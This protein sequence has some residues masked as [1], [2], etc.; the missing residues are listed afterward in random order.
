MDRSGRRTMAASSAN[1]L[2]VPDRFEALRDSASTSLST[3]IVAV[4]SALATIDDYFHDMQAA[5]RGALLIMKGVPGAGKT[6]FLETIRFFRPEVTVEHLPADEDIP[7]A[8]RGLEPK[9]TRLLVLD[10]RESVGQV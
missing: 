9:A 2:N 6:T 8:L 5:R 7:T 4:E 1:V 3:I 10:G